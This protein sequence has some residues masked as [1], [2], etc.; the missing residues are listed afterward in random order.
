MA[1][2]GKKTKKK[3]TKKAKE[4]FKLVLGL[5]Q[6]LISGLGLIALLGWV[7]ILG[8]LV[9][10]G[11]VY[12]WLDNLGVLK[13]ELPGK[14]RL[15]PAGSG[16]VPTQASMAPTGQGE[17]T[18]LTSASTSRPAPMASS[19]PKKS[20]VK[21]TS[22]PG[23]KKAAKKSLAK[24]FTFLNSPDFSHRSRAKTKKQKRHPEARST[25]SRARVRLAPQTRPDTQKTAQN[26]KNPVRTRKRSG[27]AARVRKAAIATPGQ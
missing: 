27:R 26:K 11:D 8:V 13:A 15:L 5:K 3:P 24:K 18:P 6:L 25:S 17:K 14:A 12:R 2:T 7:F 22:Q 20:Q 16:L 19:A 21:R 9:G 23:K 4:G 1:T 10:R